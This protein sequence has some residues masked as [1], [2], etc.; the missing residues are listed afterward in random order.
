MIVDVGF[1][2][3][4]NVGKLIFLLVVIKVKFKIVNYY[5]IIF[6]LNLGVV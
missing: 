6:I 5:F 2:G 3:F 4:L 1:L